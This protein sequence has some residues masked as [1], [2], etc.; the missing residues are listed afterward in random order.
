MVKRDAVLRQLRTDRSC[1]IFCAKRIAHSK[2]LKRPHWRGHAPIP[3]STVPPPVSDVLVIDTAWL[4]CILDAFRFAYEHCR[5]ASK[6]DHA[7]GRARSY[8][9]DAP[10]LDAGNRTGI[11]CTVPRIILARWYPADERPVRRLRLIEC[12]FRRY[13]R[14]SYHSR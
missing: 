14:N 13:V 9:N 1:R 12:S 8:R 2:Q 3:H 10:L 6:R 4:L 5:M 11:L 7:S